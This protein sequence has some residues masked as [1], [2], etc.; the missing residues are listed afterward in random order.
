MRRQCIFTMH[1]CDTTTIA[2]HFQTWRCRTW[3]D[4]SCL[5]CNITGK[6]VIILVFSPWVSASTSNLV[7]AERQHKSRPATTRGIEKDIFRYWNKNWALNCEGDASADNLWGL[8]W[9]IMD[10]HF[11]LGSIKIYFWF[12]SLCFLRWKVWVTLPVGDI[13]TCDGSFLERLQSALI[14]MGRVDHMTNDCNEYTWGSAFVM[15]DVCQ[16]WGTIIR[17][18][19]VPSMFSNDRSWFFSGIH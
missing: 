12:L 11:I 3:K 1:T 5:I 18:I 14:T 13:P 19:Y 6:S 2:V 9:I 4:K 7:A 17:V 10:M 8:V 16:S 15:N